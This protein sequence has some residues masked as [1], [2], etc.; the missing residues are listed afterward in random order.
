[1]EHTFREIY[2]AVH[3]TIGKKTVSRASIINFLN[4]MCDEIVFNYDE[5]TCKDGA[6]RKYLT[7]LDEVGFKKYVVRT[8]TDIF[9][10]D[11]LIQTKEIIEEVLSEDS[12][13]LSE[14]F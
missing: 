10:K 5:E 1:L 7:G 6:G 3:K 11:F 2:Q 8:A 9:M 12:Y 4:D 14:L 13:L